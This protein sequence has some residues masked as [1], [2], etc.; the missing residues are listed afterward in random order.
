MKLLRLFPLPGLGFLSLLALPLFAGEEARTVR[1]DLNAEKDSVKLAVNAT[2][3]GARAGNSEWRKDKMDYWITAVFPSEAR[4]GESSLTF[5]PA[6][7]GR[8]VI[9]L[10]GPYVRSAGADS[11]LKLIWAYFDE[12]H[13]T[14]AVVANPGFEQLQ[15]DKPASWYRQPAPSGVKLPPESLADLDPIQPAEGRFSA[16]VWH[17]SS[18]SQAI[19][20]EAGKPVTLTFRHRLYD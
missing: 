14:G 5:T 13:A 3:D 7:S 15:D 8:V 11:P 10:K 1:I 18:F 17:H 12:I 9:I 4:W 19:Q 20:V 16:R 6:A 2:S